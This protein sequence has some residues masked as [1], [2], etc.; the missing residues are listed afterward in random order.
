M[1]NSALPNI[2][3]YSDG[4]DYESISQGLT[5]SLIAGFTTNPS[6]LRRA[7]V[8]DYPAFAKRAAAL[9]YPKPISFEVLADGETDMYREAAAIASWGDNVWVKIPVID[10]QGNDTAAVLRRLADEGVK[11]NV[12]AI[13]DFPQVEA[14]IGSLSNARTPY[15]SVI[16]GRI[17]DSGVDPTQIVSKIVSL[18]QAASPAAEVLWA[19][20]RELYNVFQAADCGCKIITLPESILAKLAHMN[21]GLDIISRNTVSEFYTDAQASGLRVLPG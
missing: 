19:S 11:L 5:N 9:V 3:V 17:A 20:A 4:A 7:G 18:A 15:L 12:T 2:K 13:A 14:I 1:T 10:T 8:S 6:L 21:A 16:A